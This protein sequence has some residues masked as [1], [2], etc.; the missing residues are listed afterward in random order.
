MPSGNYWIFP[1][2][3]ILHCLIFNSFHWPRALHKPYIDRIRYYLSLTESHYTP[4][5][6]SH[7]KSLE[8]T[9]FSSSNNLP[10]RTPF[11][12][13]KGRKLQNKDQTNL[14]WF[15]LN[16]NLKYNKYHSAA[17]DFSIVFFFIFLE[18]VMGG[19][20][21]SLLSWLTLILDMELI[22]PGNWPLLSVMTQKTINI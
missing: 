15:V 22:Q 10:W 18:I 21:I 13:R 6:E 7:G 3:R 1:Q 12:S 8:W 2:L 4:T 16:V 19:G 17:S 9:T 14:K 5:N 20:T 11:I